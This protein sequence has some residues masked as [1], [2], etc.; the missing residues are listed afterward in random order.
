MERGKNERICNEGNA[1]DRMTFNGHRRTFPSSVPNSFRSVFF[2]FKLLLGNENAP[3]VLGGKMKMIDVSNS[4]ILKNK[5]RK[6]SLF[7]FSSFLLDVMVTRSLLC[8][9]EQ[10]KFRTDV[11]ENRIYVSVC[12]FRPGESPMPCISISSDAIKKR[13]TRAPI[14]GMS[15]YSKRR[16]A[17]SFIAS[18]GITYLPT[19][20]FMHRNRKTRV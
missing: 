20:Y 19:T 5:K 16:P 6:K 12:S 18:T 11:N 4:F 1:S 3:M 9:A 14:N 10:T 7:L 8:Q 15:I 2:I 13:K 17:F